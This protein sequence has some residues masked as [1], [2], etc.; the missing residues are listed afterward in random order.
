MSFVRFKNCGIML[1]FSTVCPKK[2]VIFR[3]LMGHIRCEGPL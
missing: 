3:Q 1:G 2:S